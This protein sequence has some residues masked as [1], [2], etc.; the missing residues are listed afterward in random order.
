MQGSHR[1]LLCMASA[2][3]GIIH[4]NSCSSLDP[5]GEVGLAISSSLYPLCKCWF[6]TN[7]FPSSPPE[8]P[9]PLGFS[10][11]GSSDCSYECTADQRQDRVPQFMDWCSQ[12]HLLELPSPW[13]DSN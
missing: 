11:R 1:K 5:N 13:Y 3:Q 8:S 10:Q 7:S 2:A 6:L 9:Q 4:F 12:R